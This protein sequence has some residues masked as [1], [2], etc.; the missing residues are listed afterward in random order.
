MFFSNNLFNNSVITK[1]STYLLAAGVWHY[2]GDGCVEANNFENVKATL[3]KTNFSYMF[4]IFD[5]VE[6][7]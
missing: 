2:L 3:A 6:L 7:K 4:Y 1:L 5:V